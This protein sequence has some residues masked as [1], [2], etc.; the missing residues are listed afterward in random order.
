MSDPRDND[1]SVEPFRHA[2]GAASAVATPADTGGRLDWTK[3][4]KLAWRPAWSIRSR[5]GSAGPFLDLLRS[6]RR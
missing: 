6:F 1:G 3:V 4:T 2:P 5:R